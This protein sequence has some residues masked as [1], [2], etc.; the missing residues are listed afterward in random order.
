MNAAAT[1]TATV[2]ATVKAT[3]LKSKNWRP[4]TLYRACNAPAAY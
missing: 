4:L 3:Q 2:K 1:V